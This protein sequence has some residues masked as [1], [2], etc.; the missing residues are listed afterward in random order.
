VTRH[1]TTN[2]G[3]FFAKSA[4]NLMQRLPGLPT[5]PYVEF[6]LHRKPK[7]SPLFHKHHLRKQLYTRWCC[8]DRLNRHDLPGKWNSFR[9]AR[10]P[11]IGGRL[12]GSPQLDLASQVR[13]RDVL[14]GLGLAI[15]TSSLR[16]TICSSPKW[17]FFTPAFPFAVQY[18][19][20]PRSWRDAASGLREYPSPL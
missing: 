6:L 5:T 7:P 16:K 8:I 4:P 18:P 17:P 20:K 11:L 9:V 14:L 15:S 1:Q 13:T 3:M 12:E 19:E 10:H 2:G